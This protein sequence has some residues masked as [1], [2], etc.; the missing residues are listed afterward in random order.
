MICYLLF[1][2]F[3]LSRA[4]ELSPLER[5]DDTEIEAKSVFV[6]CES[7]PIPED[8]I[9]SRQ[10]VRGGKVRRMPNGGQGYVIWRALIYIMS[11][12]LYLL[13]GGHSGLFCVPL[14]MQ[15]L[16]WRHE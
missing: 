8:S 11:L 9:Q 14:P 5:V 4:N 10:P 16:Q 3:V 2:G 1:S 6:L 13:L 7:M 12:I 15:I